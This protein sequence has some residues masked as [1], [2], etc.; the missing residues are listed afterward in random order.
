MKKLLIVGTIIGIVT[1]FIFVSIG[2]LNNKYAKEDL[3]A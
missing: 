2:M 1:N 3:G